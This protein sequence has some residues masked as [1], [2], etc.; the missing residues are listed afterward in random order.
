MA[1]PFVI[2]VSTLLLGGYYPHATLVGYGIFTAFLTRST[3]TLEG[4]TTAT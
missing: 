1:I 2:V 3:R 4:K